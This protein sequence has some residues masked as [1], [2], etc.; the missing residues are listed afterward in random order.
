VIRRW[1]LLGLLGLGG[2][3]EPDAATSTDDG[4]TTEAATST[5]GGMSTGAS[6]E[7][8]TDTGADPT[9]SAEEESTAGGCPDAVFDRTAWDE[10]CFGD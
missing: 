2:C 7:P 5:T 4:E 10:S 6:A 9:T 8:S 3:F 1:L